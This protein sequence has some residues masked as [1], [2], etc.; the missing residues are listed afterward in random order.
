MTRLDRWLD[1]AT[2]GLAPDSAAQVRREIL[3]HY[4]SAREAAQSDGAAADAEAAA[5]ASLGSPRAANCQYRKV[6]LTAGEARMLRSGNW[7]ARAVC[8]RPW[9]KW[10]MLAAPAALLLAGAILYVLGAQPLA[11]GLVASGIATAL[12]FAGP[13]LPIYTPVRS[14]IFRWTK[15]A[16][17]VGAPVAILGRQSVEWSWI[18]FSTFWGIYWVEFTRASIRGKLPVSA[19]P[20]QLYL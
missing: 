12:V 20:K 6:L 1:R 9:L 4:E 13:F 10:A 8:S 11:R 14:R 19:W 3:D 2:L 7:E 18:L 17:L 5:V 16:V 15:I